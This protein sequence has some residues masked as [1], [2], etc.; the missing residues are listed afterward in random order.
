MRGL[1]GSGLVLAEGLRHRMPAMLALKSSSSS[2]SKA[3]LLNLLE[4]MVLTALLQAIP[5][6]AGAALILKVTNSTALRP[7]IIGF[8]AIASLIHALLAA[9]LGPRYPR[10]ARQA[11]AA[12]F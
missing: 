11:Y 6:Y 10:L 9:I 12:E 4:G 8:V 5:T 3:P 1:H 7:D 2:A